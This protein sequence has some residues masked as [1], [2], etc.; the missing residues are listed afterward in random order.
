MDRRAFLQALAALGLVPAVRI[1]ELLATPEAVE[2]AARAT[3]AIRLTPTAMTVCV[4]PIEISSLDGVRRFLPGR[5][6]FDVTLADDE[7]ARA[8]AKRMVGDVFPLELD[9]CG[10]PCSI[11]RAWFGNLRCD[12]DYTGRATYQAGFECLS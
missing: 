10:F 3:W 11:E 6:F 8:L 4:E 12:V 7:G 5:R 2:P 9:C 1:P